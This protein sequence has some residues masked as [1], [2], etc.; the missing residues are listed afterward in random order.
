[1]VSHE[2]VFDTPP[3]EPL[4]PLHARLYDALCRTRSFRGG[5]MY[6]SEDDLIYALNCTPGELRR[7]LDQLQAQGF[8]I[9]TRLGPG[10]MV[11]YILRTWSTSTKG[12]LQ[13][14]LGP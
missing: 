13:L 2:Q 10:V 5:P 14:P 4:P 6:K 9:Q 7:A 11:R 1:M 3:T 8:R 12:I